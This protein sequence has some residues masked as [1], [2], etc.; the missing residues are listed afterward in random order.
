[1][2]TPRPPGRP[3]RQSSERKAPRRSELRRSEDYSGPFPFP[4]FAAQ[5]RSAVPV[6]PD[7]YGPRVRHDQLL[8]D[9]L[10]EGLDDAQREAVTTRSVPLAILAG[11]GAGKMR[12]LTRRIAW[13]ARHAHIDPGHTL[14]VT[15][16]R[17]AAGELGD[18]LRRLGVR[19]E[20]AAG[21]VHA[22][23]M[24]QLRR[25]CEDH[26]GPMPKILE[27]KARLLVPMLPGRGGERALLAAEVA[28][29]IQWAKRPLV[30]SAGYPP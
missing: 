21:T 1:M 14:A 9:P 25:R 22:I 26:D 17:K 6:V 19:R 20:G 11:A 27:R 2:G 23:A 18:R 12:V 15:F 16:T 28:S 29:E 13:Q 30:G 4:R 24:A 10:L 8:E 7:R 5:G 3:Q